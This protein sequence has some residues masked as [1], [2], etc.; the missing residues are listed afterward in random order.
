MNIL[1]DFSS[2]GGNKTT[3]ERIRQTL[4]FVGVYYIFSL[5]VRFIVKY[6]AEKWLP[7][8]T[9]FLDPLALSPIVSGVTFVFFLSVYAAIRFGKQIEKKG[10][11]ALAL[12][13]G[14]AFV[15][16]RMFF[17]YTLGLML[18]TAMGIDIET[19]GYPMSEAFWNS[20][21]PDAIVLFI[22]LFFVALI[23]VNITKES[24]VAQE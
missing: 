3:A 24:A 21:T 17:V 22:D 8:P 12:G 7:E 18:L 1:D 10:T 15:V 16:Y 9:L 6:F 23:F 13:M 20:F 2:I 14:F 19:E 5:G 11:L 4:D